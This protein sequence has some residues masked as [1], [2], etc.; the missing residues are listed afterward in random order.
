[1]NAEMKASQER[2]TA[3]M[4]VV[5]AE[6]KT[7]Y[8]EMDT[9]EEAR[10]ERFLARLDGVTSY[11]EIDILWRRNDDLADDVVFR[12]NGSHEFGGEPRRNRGRSGAAGAL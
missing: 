2:T 9:R 5:Q 3:E 7:A 12:G 4:R 6:I 8:A 11:G 1:M 10:H